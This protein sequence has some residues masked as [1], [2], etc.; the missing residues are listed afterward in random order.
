MSFPTAPA[1]PP[2]Q[3]QRPQNGLGTAG[4]VLGL[5]GLVFSVIPIIGVVAWPLVI[6]GL[7]FS[8]IGFFRGRAGRATNKGLALAGAILSVIGLL[9]CILYLAAFGKA[10]N[11][12]SKEANQTVTISYDAG[13]TA[14]D[15]TVTYS[16]FST[17]GSSEGQQDTSLPW[18][19]DVKATGFGRGGI[20]TVTA[21][22]D[23]GTV[24]CKVTVN[25]VVQKTSSASGVLASAT[26][27][28]F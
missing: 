22:V 27:S 6:L 19:K 25:G 17:G 4:F 24:T 18:H 7:I 21:G 13:G 26:C 11:D 20:L 28:N 15:A 12:I 8:L 9:M 23:G 5:I 2:Q 16:T 14:K 1:A 3:L 10:A